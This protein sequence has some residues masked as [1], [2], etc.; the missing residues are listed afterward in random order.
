MVLLTRTNP[1]KSTQARFAERTPSYFVCMAFSVSSG[2]QIPKGLI[3]SLRGWTIYFAL[4]W[5][6]ALDDLH[7]VLRGAESH[8][9]QVATL[10]TR[11]QMNPAMYEISIC[12]HEIRQ[13]LTGAI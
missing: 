11:L 3:F 1:P 10:I 8:Q 6:T 4:P 12:I 9:D 7:G 13:S 2:L 5:H